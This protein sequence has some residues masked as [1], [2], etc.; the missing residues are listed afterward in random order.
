MLNSNQVSYQCVAN[1][2]AA[3]VDNDLTCTHFSFD[4]LSVYTNFNIDIQHCVEP[5]CSFFNLSDD[6]L[7][8]VDKKLLSYIRCHYLEHHKFS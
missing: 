4:W 3:L 1:M 2:I 6:I 8:I 7:M 5:K